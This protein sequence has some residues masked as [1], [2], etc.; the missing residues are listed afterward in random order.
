MCV[1]LREHVRIKGGGGKEGE[2]GGHS[3]KFER[4][5]LKEREGKSVC[6]N[7]TH[8]KVICI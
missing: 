7:K 2:K 5:Q 6:V 3:K 4:L 8:V 1:C